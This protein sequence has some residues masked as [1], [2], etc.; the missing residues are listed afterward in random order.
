MKKIPETSTASRRTFFAGAMGNVV[1]LLLLL[2]LFLFLAHAPGASAQ[3]LSPSGL[4]QQLAQAETDLSAV[5]H[6]LDGRIDASGLRLLRTKAASAGNIAGSAADQLQAQLALVDAKITELG[7][8][9]TGVTEAPDIHAQRGALGRQRSA[10]DSAVKRGRLLGV[11]SQQ[12]VSEIDQSQAAQFGEKVSARTPSPL[13][14]GFWSAFVQA[15]P[16]DIR[17]VAALG[18][19]GAA[20]IAAHHTRGFPWPAILGL[21]LAILVMIPARAMA[22]RL[23]QRFLTYG[24]PGRRV[25]RSANAL[26]RAVV[27]TLAPLIASLLFVQGLRWSALLPD[28]WAPL[29]D[30]FVAAVTLSA[31]TISV[32]GALLMRSRPSWRVAPMSDEAASRLRPFSWALGFLAFVAITLHAFNDAVGASAAAIAATQALVA[33]LH[34]LLIGATLI[35]FGRLRAAQAA[36]EEETASSRAGFGAIAL[37][38]WLLVTVS[39]LALLAGYVSF[40][41]FLVQMI[42]WAALLSA[43]A[44]L[45][46]AA[47]DDLATTIFDRSSPLGLTLVR[48]LGL[49]GSAVDQF[50]VLLSGVLRLT[51]ALLAIGLLLSPF[52]SGVGSIFGRLGVLA[53]GFDVGGVAISPGVI[54]RGLLVLFIGLALLRAFM[55]WLDGRYLPATDLDGSGRNSVSLVARYVGIALAVIWSLASLGIGVEKIA[56]LLSA[57]SVG[58]GFGLQAITQNFVSGLILLA[59]RPIKIGDLVR[60][61]TDEGDVKRISVRSTEIELPDHSTLIVPN[62]ELITKSVLNK[63]LASPLGRVQIQFSVPIETDADVVRDIVID[64]FAGESTILDTPGPSVFI[65][66]IV[67]GRILFNCFAHVAN[68]RAAYSARSGVLMTLLRRFRADGIEV[69]SMPQKFEMVPVADV[70]GKAPG[71]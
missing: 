39:F 63:T 1:A 38:A 27:G 52:G 59:E 60:V 7:P 37:V 11:E 46:T 70:A 15:F 4:A 47:I 57:L 29:F 9:P 64:A 58:I 50:G 36:E 2:A 30:G 66:G 20:E 35:A 32:T 53:Q 68:P 65:D 18:E 25:R 19:R 54:L 16:R 43:G 23:G 49:K 69:G 14:P 67:D 5:D 41:L 26:W 13:T 6:A 31:L 40:S 21:V 56:I 10:L 34:L 62:S 44:Y 48:G 17:R 22:L 55:G 45:L 71:S 61:G 28:L 8:V 51:V 33:L 12:L 42:A 3:T 24:A